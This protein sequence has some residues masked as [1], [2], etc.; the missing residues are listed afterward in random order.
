MSASREPKGAETQAVQ[1]ST[2]PADQQCKLAK[3]YIDAIARTHKLGEAHF[4]A[5]MAAAHASLAVF[6]ELKARRP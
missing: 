4:F 6:E 3:G 2:S 1:T 5:T